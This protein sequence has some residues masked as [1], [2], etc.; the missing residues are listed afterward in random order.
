[1][2]GVIPDI[3]GKVSVAKHGG[4]VNVES[5]SE[6]KKIAEYT[7]K[8]CIPIKVGLRVNIDID[9]D[10]K[11]KSR[12]GVA[13]GTPMFD[14]CLSLQSDTLQIVG[15]HCHIHGCRSL[16]HWRER[17]I[18]LG[19]ISKKYGFEY[20]DF[21]SNMFGFMDDR[22]KAQ[23]NE[24]VPS[25]S[26]YAAT[27]YGGLRSVYGREKLPIVIIEPGTPVVADAVSLLGKVETI[28]ELE[29]RTIATA[30]CSVYDFGFFHGSDKHPPMDVIYV[31]NEL[32]Y[33]DVEIF[34]YACTEDDTV[35]K[36]YSGL[37][38]EGDLLLFR[39]L[40]AYAN[41]L[42]SDFIKKKLKVIEV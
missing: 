11:W 30:S 7:Q 4:I 34:G 25:A 32:Y 22:L 2:N 6:L 15:I 14:K 27:I 42:C 17:A 38:G 1:M 36:S 18:Q 37:L 33:K 20:I 19:K 5:Y 10:R 8:N 31:G 3:N 26:E 9:N 28:T 13:P 39:N 35:C 24:Y 40:G 16:I 12:F 41:S 29:D 23:F 21:G